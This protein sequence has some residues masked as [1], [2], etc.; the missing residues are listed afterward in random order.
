VSDTVSSAITGVSAPVIVS[1]LGASNLGI[2]AP[3]AAVTGTPIS[4][5]VRALDPFGNLVPGYSGSVHFTSSDGGAQ[6]PGNATLTAGQGV[7]SAT[8]QTPGLETL[9]AADTVA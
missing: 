1:S 9:S 8:L 6:L 3:G 4:F 7:F 5:T 2:T